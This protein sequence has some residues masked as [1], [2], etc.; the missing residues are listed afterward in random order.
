M[1]VADVLLVLAP[2]A[3][4][5]GLVIRAMPMAQ[6]RAERAMY[7]AFA[8]RMSFTERMTPPPFC[9]EGSIAD[10]GRRENGQNDPFVQNLGKGRKMSEIH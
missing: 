3:V 1:S 5:A 8:V 2:M 7:A 4:G 6:N 10:S 9:S